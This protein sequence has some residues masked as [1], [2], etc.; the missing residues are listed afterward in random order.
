MPLKINSGKKPL[1]LY[2]R[3]TCIVELGVFYTTPYS[4]KHV[5]QIVKCVYITLIL[6]TLTNT[7]LLELTMLKSLP[8][9]CTR[10]TLTT[11]GPCT[12]LGCCAKH[13]NQLRTSPTFD[14]TTCSPTPTTLN[15]LK[16]V[17]LSY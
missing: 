9:Y 3:V 8:S 16:Y 11:L 13:L 4:Q 17:Q 7:V 10:H 6:I 15:L 12:A 1:N 14:P 5:L 2:K